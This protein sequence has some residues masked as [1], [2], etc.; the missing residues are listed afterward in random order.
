LKKKLIIGCGIGLV[1]IIAV[2]LVLVLGG[3]KKADDKKDDNKV[4][5]T[6]TLDINPSLEMDLNSKKD[7]L[8]V[9]ALNGDANLILEADLKGKSWDDA[10]KGIAEKVIEHGFAQ[11][12]QVVMII[13][14][15]GEAKGEEL[16]NGIR[17][18]FGE[19][20]LDPD[21]IV[22][23]DISE[24][25]K[26]LAKQYNITPAKAAYINKV[27][28]ENTNVKF[29][30]LV[31]KP[32]KEL[33]ETK[34]TG[35]YCDEGWNLEGDFCVR[36][37]ERVAAVKSSVCPKDSEEVKGVCYKRAETEQEPYCKNGL[38]LKDGKCVGTEKVNAEAQCMV[39]Q[40]E[41]NSKSGKCEASTYISAGTKACERSEDKMINGRCASPH[42][43]AHFD[44]PEGT[45]DPANECCCGDTWY[46]DSS[47]PGR[48]W[49]YNENG[50]RDAI[51]KCPSGSTYKESGTTGNGCYAVVQ[52]D[53]EYKCS[54]G[55]LDGNKC[56]VEVSK[57]PEYKAS[58]K[59]GLTL[60][61]NRVCIDKNSTVEKEEG[62]SCNQKDSKLVGDQCVLME[63]VD[64]K[65]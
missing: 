29:E 14:V 12:D 33:K 20:N 18:V 10:L 43:G 53:P 17:H 50:D 35:K 21:V 6:V 63:I 26:E 9:R 59:S 11:E 16:S 3:K 25:D 54:K 52:T 30:Q 40:S 13:N 36:E 45:I 24:E 28:E 62:Y 65:Q 51:T 23:E 8:D 47:A 58:C 15:T 48:G 31:E 56:T 4:A 64:A 46:P 49:C 41:Y 60:H 22:I 5:S 32:V 2:V 27:V 38:T 44:D 39:S 1:V 57:N 42:M 34:E 61:E 7:V 19:K 55:T 37:K